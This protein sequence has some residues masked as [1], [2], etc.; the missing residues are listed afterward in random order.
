MQQPATDRLFALWTQSSNA[1]LG[2]VVVALVLIAILIAL[3]NRP[4]DAVLCRL[5]DD[6]ETTR[7]ETSNA[8]MALGSSGLDEYR[9]V[10]GQICVA[11]TLKAKYLSVIKDADALP[12]IYQIPEETQVNPFMLG[13]Q[14]KLQ[15]LNRKKQYVRNMVLRLPAVSEVLFEM[16][17]RES[18]S[19]FKPD[20]QSAALMV[21]MQQG[22][23]LTANHVRTIQGIVCG[24]FAGL[25]PT[26]VLVTDANTGFSYH[27]LADN[28]Q[29]ELIE[30]VSWKQE[31]TQFYLH[32][33]QELKN[34]FPNLE[35]NV[36]IHRRDSESPQPPKR[37]KITRHSIDRKTARIAVNVGGSI[38]E[39]S[40][41]T[42]AHADSGVVRASHESTAFTPSHTTSN[43]RSEII[44]IE[45]RVPTE[46]ISGFK[47][48]NEK[49]SDT[50]K[51]ESLK[52][53][54][55][56]A[57]KDIIPADLLAASPPISIYAKLPQDQGLDARMVYVVKMLQIYWPV[58]AVVALG[59]IFITVSR[60][61][62]TV[63]ETNSSE[64]APEFGEDQLQNQLTTLIDSD[65]DAAATVIKN[66]IRN[67]A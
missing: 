1:R 3:L 47:P 40:E 46:L 17:L 50:E 45:I 25:T 56:A 57:I 60:R 49:A 21:S 12:Q 53:N 28:N 52:A 41:F 66:W 61:E 5:F 14:Q 34:S 18:G 11:E 39:Q 35:I 37:D 54:I 19:P 13:R 62:K 22:T 8:L 31:R 36:E 58:L 29:L 48:K 10:D 4:S 64:S 59:L 23:V 63:V 6:Y 20:Q 7:N 32:K 15:E 24:S 9:I 44:K 30:L 26:Q 65:P 55:V 42:V 33:L 51:F 43:V 16:D 2:I 67:A 38:D 27:D